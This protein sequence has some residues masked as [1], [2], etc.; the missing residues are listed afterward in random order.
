MNSPVLELIQKQNLAYQVSGQ[1]YVVRCLNPE[2]PDNSPSLRIDKVTGSFHCFACHFKG[3]IFKYFGVFTNT[4]PLKILNLKEKLSKLK[5]YNT[6]L[7]LPNGATPYTRSF[8][9][10]SVKTLKEFGAFYTLLDEKLLDRICFPV[11]DITGKIVVFVARH[12]F[13]QGNPRY[14][15]YP[16]GVSLPLFPAA[17]P[18]TAKTM[19][20]VEGLFDFLNL[21]DKGLKNV[22][23]CFGTNTLQKDTKQKLLP[24]KA[25]GITKIYLLFDGDEAGR[26]ASQMLQPLIEA[27][28][29]LVE[30]IK[31]PDGQD[32][33]DLDDETVLSIKE[34]TTPQVIG[35]T[36]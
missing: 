27:E 16:S 30:I 7:D 2:H 14:I 5:S 34:Y 21:W 9:N 20:L 35:T 18:T 28:G 15:N 17:A 1:D 31:L 36:D 24:F 32:P 23:C 22:A 12:T 13:S 29:F 25:Q 4:A 6:G 3:N 11:K 26:K 10:I 33:G 8:R 19:V